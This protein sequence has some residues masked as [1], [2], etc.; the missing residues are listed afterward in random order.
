V[1]KKMKKL[2][3]PVLACLFI[4]GTVYASGIKVGEILPHVQIADKGQMVPDYT[5]ENNKMVF[6]EG[7]DITYRP[8]DSKELIGKIRCI[9]HLAAR[10]GVDEIN[11]PFID[12]LIAADLP[13]YL[14]GSPYKTTTILNTD[15][16]LWGTSG[17]ATGRFVKSQKEVA[18]AYY[19]TDANGVARQAWGLKEKGSSVIIVDKDGKVLYFI[20]GKMTEEDIRKTVELVKQKL[21]RS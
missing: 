15:D 19:V 3:L 7:A 16:A 14:P 8:W 17:I 12:A 2:V 10:S 20:D 4:S 18:Y 1:E 6:R 13:E 9:Y 21:N 11:K 5:I